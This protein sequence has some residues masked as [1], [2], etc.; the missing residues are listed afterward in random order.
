MHPGLLV[1]SDENI[2]VLTIRFFGGKTSSP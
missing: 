1:F 2:Y